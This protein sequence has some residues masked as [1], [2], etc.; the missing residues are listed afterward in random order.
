[1]FKFLLEKDTWQE[2]FDSLSK[3]KLR[4]ILTMVGV[5]WGILL[6]IGL[7]GSA[8]GLENSFNVLFGDFATNSVFVWGQST[9]KPFKGFQEGREVKLSLSDAKKIE[10]NVEGIE[11]VLPRNQRSATVTKNFLSG[12]F[13]MAGDYPLLDKLQK[14]KLIH[15]RF[16]NQ[17]D[18]DD[19]KKIVV[20]S[21]DAYKQLYEKDAEA[22]GTYL[23]INDINFKVVGMFDSGNVNMGPSTDMH[24]PFTTYQQIYN[25]GDRIGWMMITG[26][27]EYDIKQIEEDSKLLLKNLNNI[28]PEDKRAF[29]SFNLGKEFS[30]MTG[31]LT[32]MQFLTWFVG[33]ATLIAGVFAIGNI[34]LITVKERTKE[35]G[36]RRALGATPFEIKRQIVVEAVFLTLVAGLF[37]IISGGL[38]LILLDYL[39]GQGADA[40]LVNASVSIGV[41]FTALLILVV[42]G[43]LIGLIPATKATSIKPIE[44]LREE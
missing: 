33:I 20:I 39:F 36:V 28:H 3:N 31:F 12:S 25:Q 5:W 27:P 13:Q 6:L 38:I 30:K 7:L 43:T 19:N 23:I 34:L 41:V 32:G 14:K 37:G 10:E 16:I 26:K 11:F 15:G 22:I 8:R 35:I 4:S 1:M 44:A 18:I 24:I 9:G 29:G 2:V 40:A 42:L 21:E 17:N